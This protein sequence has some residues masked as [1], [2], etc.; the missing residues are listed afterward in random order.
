[1]HWAA[2]G[3]RVVQVL[4]SRITTL[5]G[6]RPG[7]Y[8]FTDPVFDPQGRF[9]SGFLSRGPESDSVGSEA[10]TADHGPQ[11]LDVA[12]VVSSLSVVHPI[13]PGSETHYR[14]AVS[15]S[16]RLTLPDGR[17]VKRFKSI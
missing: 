11:P 10:G 4:G 5:E 3:S 8:A 17:S 7:G 16:V 14:Y 6:S 15:D 1:M 12:Q 9:G 2:D 13:A